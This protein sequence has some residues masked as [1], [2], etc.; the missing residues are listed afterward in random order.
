MA[1]TDQRATK[2]NAVH[3]ISGSL[4]QATQVTDEISLEAQVNKRMSVK[5]CNSHNK[6]ASIGYLQLPLKL[7]F[8]RI[9]GIKES[10]LFLS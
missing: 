1:L 3:L 5:M 2:L 9:R 10:Y 8:I 4:Y 6:S 7:P